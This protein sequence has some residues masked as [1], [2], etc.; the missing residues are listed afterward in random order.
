MAVV[1]YEPNTHF[2]SGRR[3]R[4]PVPLSPHCPPTSAWAARPASLAVSAPQ[5]YFYKSCAAVLRTTLTLPYSERSPDCRLRP[6]DPKHNHSEVAFPQV[7]ESHLAFE[8]RAG[9]MR[10]KAVAVECSRPSAVRRP[11]DKAKTEPRHMNRPRPAPQ[12]VLSK[13]E[14]LVNTPPPNPS[15]EGTASGLRPPAAPHV[16]R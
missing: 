14:R 6:S 7:I 10:R 3:R 8:S 4:C 1:A 5:S 2:C 11:G 16:E 9:T 15:I 13:Q 12:V